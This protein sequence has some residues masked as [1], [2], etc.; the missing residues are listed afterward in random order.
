MDKVFFAG[1]HR[2]RHP[3][4][5]LDLITPMFPDFGV[6]RLADVTGLDILGIPVVMAVRPLAATL[7]VSQGKGADLLPAKVS[8]AM[9]AIELWHAES[10][11]PAPV[12][13]STSAA[14]LGIGY[15][16]ADVDDDCNLVGDRCPLDWIRG[17][18][19]VSGREVLVPRM[20]V[21]MG[22]RFREDRKSVV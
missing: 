15:R 8:G 1:T 20:S 18:G 19:A 22:W 6:T 17:R 11:V 10:A 12:L 14:E 9:E 7:S 13:T 5:T 21:H 4:E 2:V 16:V 3:Q